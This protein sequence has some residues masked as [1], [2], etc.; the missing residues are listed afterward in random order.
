M[1]GTPSNSRGEGAQA[2]A[3]VADKAMVVES[4][5][6]TAGSVT[7]AMLASTAVTNAKVAPG[8]AIQ[9]SKL[10]LAQTTP[11]GLIR[12]GQA[13]YH[14]PPAT[15]VGT[16]ATGTAVLRAF[17]V[18]LEAGLTL[19]RLGVEVTTGAASSVARLG[20]YSTG[21]DGAP[22]A[23]LVDAGTVATT[24]AGA[25]EVTLSQAITATGW[26]WLACASQGGDPTYRSFTS[27]TALL[28]NLPI[29]PF[30]TTTPTS[31]SLSTAGISQSGITGALPDPFGLSAAAASGAAPRI[32]FRVV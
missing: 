30:G 32:W 8:A 21:S 15:A 18:Y 25:K 1:P 23:L 22:G 11:G 24:S 9:A 12:T 16:N 2:V 7:E 20:I 28:L 6:W 13:F 5:A 27:T 19:D 14:F 29:V 31:G 3:P 10:N 26:Y 4:G 17:P